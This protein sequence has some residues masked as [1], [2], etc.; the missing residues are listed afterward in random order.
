MKLSFHGAARHVTGSKHLLR[1]NEEKQI[2]LDCGM[3]QGLGQDTNELN[4]NWGFEPSA[5]S[6]VVLSHAHIDHIGLL[7]K[8]VKDGY[9]GKIYCTPATA[10]LAK[11]LLVDS[12][13]IQEA[14]VMY[15]NKHRKKENRELIAPLY[16]EEDAVNVFPLFETIPYN[17]PCTLDEGVELVYTDVGH[18]L[19]SAAVNLKIKEKG[20]TIRLTFS[21]DV[22]RYRD[23]ILR[24]PQDFPQAD[25]IIM[26]STYGDRLHDL[27]SATSDHL[28]E[29]IVNTCLKKK[30]KLIVPAFSLG[31]TQEILYLLNRLELENRLPPLNYYV[32]SPLSVK[33]TE[34]IKRYP[35][36]FNRSVQ[37]LLKR[38]NDVFSFKGLKHIQDVK[39]SIK[40]NDTEEPCVIISASG[41]AEAGRVKHHIANNVMNERNTI[42]LTGYCEP[43]SLGG[44]LKVNTGE[45]KIFGKA[46][47]V[48]AQIAEITSLSAHGDYEDMSQWLSCQD[49]RQVKK[50]FLV[51]GDYEVQQKFRDRLI[52]K[53]FEDVEIPEQHQSFGI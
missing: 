27:Q 9:A 8:L 52:R 31:R 6:H 45:V 11:I 24:S 48:R 13:R 25:Y 34:A 21:G 18:I 46:F 32:D 37:S 3:F 42:L 10:T 2:L 36:C 43:R 26:E 12:A 7:P 16:T 50:M 23:M 49:P 53:G 51:H 30:G 5:I 47:P 1:I 40:L 29:H 19:G 38:D 17:E 44:R 14:D 28:L 15:V 35:S 33:V 22:G 41:M 20:I 39:E 4:A